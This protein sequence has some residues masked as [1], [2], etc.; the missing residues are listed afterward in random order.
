M[1]VRFAFAA[2]LAFIIGVEEKSCLRKFLQENNSRRWAS[3]PGR[4]RQRHGVR[5]FQMGRFGFPK[6]LSE[7]L[8][9]VCFA[10]ALIEPGN[11]VV[12][13]QVF[14]RHAGLGLFRIFSHAI[15]L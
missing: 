8:D 14:K 12:L 10:I 1:G 4:R 5:L 2:L 9:W 6:P 15:L 7:L 13:S 11:A 3:V